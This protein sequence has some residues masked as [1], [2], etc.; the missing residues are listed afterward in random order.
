MDQFLF[1]KLRSTGGDVSRSLSAMAQATNPWIL[2]NMTPTKLYLYTQQYGGGTTKILTELESFEK[3]YINTINEGDNLYVF[4]MKEGKLTPFMDSY[5]C[6]EFRKHIRIGAITYSSDG[7]RNEVRASNWDMRG[8]W[9]H[10]KLAVPLNIHY[11]GRLAA[12][13]YGNT[14]IDYMGGGG[15]SIYFDNDREGLDF[16]DEITFSYAIDGKNDTKYT[17]AILNDVQCVSMFVGVVSGGWWGNTNDNA[18]YR[19]NEPVF[20]G[21][22]RFEQTSEQYRTRPTYGL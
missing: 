9:I 5:I 15:S 1:E 12:Q 16:M 14:G 10:N 18:V 3:R 13:I 22:I 20:T 8:V 7:G 2:E 6:R 11:K 4:V 17:T 21:I 19:V